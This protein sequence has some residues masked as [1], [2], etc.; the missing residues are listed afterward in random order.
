MKNNR[1]LIHGE[2]VLIPVADMPSG[3]I[4]KMKSYIIGHSESGHNHV[5]ESPVEFEVLEKEDNVWVRLMGPATVRHNKTLEIH[6]TKTL[7]PG[8]YKRIFATEYSPW[9]KVVRRIFD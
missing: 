4:T 9:D 3:H 7:Q 6:E 2:N 5:L 8:V 1:V